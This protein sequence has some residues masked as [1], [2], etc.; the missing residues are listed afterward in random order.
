MQLLITLY[1]ISCP[2]PQKSP[3]YCSFCRFF[4]KLLITFYK[5]MFFIHS[6]NKIVHNFLLI[7]R[8][9][10]AKKAAFLAVINKL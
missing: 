2:Y 10:K 5:Y 8:Q 7:N 6:K 3:K 9:F 1:T 4:N